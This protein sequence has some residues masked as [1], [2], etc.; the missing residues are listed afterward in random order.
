MI[1]VLVVGQTPPP[2]GGQAIMIGKLL[3]TSR[4]GLKLAHVRM[5]FS[6]DMDAVGKVKV[7]KLLHLVSVIVRIAWRRVTTGS[8]ILYY[9]PAGP[10]RVPMMRDL[11]ILIATRW[12]FR[13]TVF[14]F[15]AGGLSEIYAGLSFPLRLLFRL[16]YSRPDVSIRLSEF[17]PEDGKALGAR[18]ETII[19]NGVEDVLSVM[20]SDPRHRGTAV[21]RARI[22]FVGILCESKGLLVLLE[23][24]GLLR[25]RGVDAAV[26]AMGRFESP[27]FEAEARAAAER[28]G[29]AD[30]VTYLGVLAGQEKWEAF[31][32]ADILCFPTFFESESFGLVLLEAMCLGLPVVATRWRGIPSVVEDGGN[33]FLVPVRDPTALAD[34]LEALA[35]DP[36]LRGR[37]GARG[38]EIFESRFGL[39]AF[40]ERMAGV[41][42]SLA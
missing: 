13:K 34:R 9:P 7:G 16:A 4:P 21:G 10:N 30:A 11:A 36:A 27:G 38:R 18:C 41:F 23:A 26:E 6:R 25:Q 20:G 42:A 24:C 29:V 19:P 14:H 33:G 8:S 37:M 22:L 35:R 2:Y 40:Q 39:E 17:N 15:H 3:E 31:K 5:D 12:M 28:W 32:S 1:K